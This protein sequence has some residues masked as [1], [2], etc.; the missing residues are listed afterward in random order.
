MLGNQIIEINL[1]QHV[2]NITCKLPQ[3]QMKRLHFVEV[4]KYTNIK[5]T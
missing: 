5:Y 3:Y 1:F 4:L 2:F